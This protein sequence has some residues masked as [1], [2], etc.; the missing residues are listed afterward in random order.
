MAENRWDWYTIV[1]ALGAGLF[2]LGI[3]SAGC[4]RM[5]GTGL[6]LNCEFWESAGLRVAG[7]G[8]VIVAAAIFANRKQKKQGEAP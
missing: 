3:G 8:L 5:V 4:E 2:V 7:L 6:R 1:V